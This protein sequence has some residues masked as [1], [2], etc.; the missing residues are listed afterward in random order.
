MKTPISTYQ[1][2][3]NL[4]QGQGEPHTSSCT[5][6]SQALKWKT[7]KVDQERAWRE[8]KH[9][10]QTTS[11]YRSGES[12]LSKENT[13]TSCTETLEKECG[14]DS[15]LVKVPS[16]R[17]SWPDTITTQIPLNKAYPTIL[18]C[19]FIWLPNTPLKKQALDTTVRCNIQGR[20]WQKLPN[21]E[22]GATWP[23]RKGV[24]SGFD[25]L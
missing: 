9:A 14:M 4:L 18:F 3:K 13:I 15:H 1:R 22:E 16:H 7:P 10:V 21:D 19:L 11:I 24:I 23:S 6:C 5:I 2:S 20:R 8:K 25:L 12:R 17:F